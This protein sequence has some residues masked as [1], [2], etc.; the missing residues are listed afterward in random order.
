MKTSQ[1]PALPSGF[2]GVAAGDLMALVEVITPDF[3]L[4]DIGRLRRYQMAINVWWDNGNNAILPVRAGSVFEGPEAIGKVLLENVADYKSSLVKIGNKLQMSIRFAMQNKKEAEHA[5]VSGQNRGLD[6]MKWLSQRQAHEDQQL[7][8]IDAAVKKLSKLAVDYQYYTPTPGA[9]FAEAS[10]LL[11]QERL[12]DFKDI[13]GSCEI[14]VVVT[15]P[16]P[17]YDFV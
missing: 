17:P 4:T 2:G 16:F 7:V 9:T 14:P 5:F 13:I 8:L 10:F 11:P 12:A 3:D 1:N 15:G 6:Y